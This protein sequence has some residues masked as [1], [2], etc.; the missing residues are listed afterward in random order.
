VFFIW[1]WSVGT[2]ISKDE[3]KCEINVCKDADS[4]R[5]DSSEGVCYCFKD[6]E[7]MKQEIVK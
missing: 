1:A 3:Q 4:F 2:K 5:Y 7:L 6:N